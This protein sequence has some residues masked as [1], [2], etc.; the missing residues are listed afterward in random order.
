MAYDC[1]VV[2]YQPLRY[3]FGLS[4]WLCSEESACQYRGHKR[5]KFNP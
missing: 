2:I 4:T 1:Y 3:M 5:L